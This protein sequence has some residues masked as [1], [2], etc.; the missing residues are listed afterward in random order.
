MASAYPA[1]AAPLGERCIVGG[2]GTVAQGLALA[3]GE[4]RFSRR[5]PDATDDALARFVA[6]W[7]WRAYRPHAD[8][9]DDWSVRLRVGLGRSGETIARFLA[10][11]LADT[12]FPW[13][14]LAAELE[15][16]RRTLQ[17]QFADALGQS[18]S[19]VL[20]AMRIELAKQLLVDPARV[21]GDIGLACGFS[22][23][24]HFSTAFKLATGLSPRDYRRQLASR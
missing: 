4:L 22:S 3:W 12:P 16:S 24:S 1:D 20:A 19:Q 5:A 15:I 6:G 13:D 18:T 17:R 11:H 7:L 9:A 14:E 10:A 23:H 2:A 21:L 8:L